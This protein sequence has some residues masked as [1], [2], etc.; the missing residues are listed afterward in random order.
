MPAPGGVDAVISSPPYAEIASGA[1]GLNTKPAKDGQQGGRNP[2]SASQD[3]DRR[4]GESEGQLA[5]LSKGEVDAVIASPPYE[6]NPM[7]PSLPPSRVRTSSDPAQHGSAGPQYV[8]GTSNGQLGQE[9]G[10]TFWSAAR[11]I[12][13]ESYAIL[14]PEGVAVWVVKHFV[15]NKQLVDFPG[16]WRKL[17]EHVG[18]E[19]IQEVHASLISEEARPDLFDGIRKTR[20]ERKSFFRRLAEKKGSPRIDFEVVLF[21]VKR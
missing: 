4:Y 8:N 12:V 2:S 17:C 13:A 15:R 20:R 5:R 11:D 6:A 16:D 19:T 7:A 21:M 9:R 1:G 14:R 3:T 10:D 18:F